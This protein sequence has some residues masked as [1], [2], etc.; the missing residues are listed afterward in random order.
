MISLAFENDA[1]VA[2]RFHW[3]STSPPA[4]QVT[5][6]ARFVPALADWQPNRKKLPH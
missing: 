1:L 5:A 4:I 3:A 6:V 2:K